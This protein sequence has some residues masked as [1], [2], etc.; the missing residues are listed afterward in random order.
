MDIAQASEV[1]DAFTER[2]WIRHSGFL[3]MGISRASSDVGWQIR[4]VGHESD[5]VLPPEFRGI[6]VTYTKEA[7]E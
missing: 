4:V 5:P 1:L 6:P 7:E 3:C 2:Y